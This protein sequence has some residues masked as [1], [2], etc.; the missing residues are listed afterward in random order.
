MSYELLTIVANGAKGLKNNIKQ[1]LRLPCQCYE[2]LRMLTNGLANVTNVNL[3]MMRMSYQLC[4]CP[5]IFL[6]MMRIFDGEAATVWRWRWPHCFLEFKRETTR[7]FIPNAWT[8]GNT[9]LLLLS[10]FAS[11]SRSR[12]TRAACTATLYSETR[13][14]KGSHLSQSECFLYYFDTSLRRI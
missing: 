7:I 5:T 1:M 6:R 14:S 4:H 3:S 8:P 9:I 12:A 11:S 13:K 10:S 2:C